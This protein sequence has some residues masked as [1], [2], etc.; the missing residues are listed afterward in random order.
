MKVEW[1]NGGEPVNGLYEV[2][3]DTEDGREPVTFQLIERM[4][5]IAMAH[6]AAKEDLGMAVPMMMVA[7]E[8]PALIENLYSTGSLTEVL[9]QLQGIHEARER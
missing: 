2:I 4:K 5:N 8:N 1:R 6:L 3:V 7:L 9:A